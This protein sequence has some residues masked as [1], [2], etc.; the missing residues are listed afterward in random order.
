MHFGFLLRKVWK[1]DAALFIHLCYTDCGQVA[2]RRE[3][4]KPIYQIG[5]ITAY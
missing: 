2:G 5:M 1:K 4:I 3:T